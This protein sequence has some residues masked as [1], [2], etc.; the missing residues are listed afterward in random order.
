MKTIQWIGAGL[1]VFAVVIWLFNKLGVGSK[2]EEDDKMEE[3]EEET[4]EKEYETCDKCGKEVE[5]N[6]EG[7]I[8][9]YECVECG[10]NC[11]DDCCVQFDE[12]DNIYCKDCIDEA[13][14]REKEVVEKIV[15]KKVYKEREKEE[16]IKPIFTKGKT[17][18]D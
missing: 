6:E 10:D 3:Q 15:E 4:E 12:S 2:S 16:E 8:D 18:F 7:D 11:C 1:I 13:Y 9:I 17:K 5:E 14:P